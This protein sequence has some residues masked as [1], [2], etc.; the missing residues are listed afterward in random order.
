MNRFFQTIGSLE[1]ITTVFYATINIFQQKNVYILVITCLI[2]Q[3]FANVSFRKG[4]DFALFIA[5]KEYEEWADLRNPISDAEIIAGELA[6]EYDFDT[7]II[8]NPNR[9]TIYDVLDNYQKKSFP[10][11]SQLLVFFTG[12]GEFIEAN[13]EGYFIPND[14]KLND[15]Y[16]DSYIT[17]S[18]IRKRVNNINC[19]HVLL[20]IDACY[21]G[22]IDER[23]AS[24]ELSFDKGKPGTRPGESSQTTKQ[25]F[26]RRTL[27]HKTR[28]F[29]TSGG[30]ERTPD[31]IRYSP[32]TEHF[33]RGLRDYK[34]G[35]VTFWDLLAHLKRAH[36]VPHFGEFGHHVP[37]GDFI[38]VSNTNKETVLLNSPKLDAMPKDPSG[39]AYNTIE[40]NGKTWLKEN[41]AYDLEQ[42]SWCYDNKQ[43]NCLKYGCLYT[44]E[45][46]KK[47][48]ELLGEG[49]RLPTDEELK[50]L[51]K[52]AGGYYYWKTGKVGNNE[53]GYLELTKKGANGFSVLLSGAGAVF[54][55]LED[56]GDNYD[57]M[58]SEL[59]RFGYLWSSI[60]REPD[61]A[62]H[63]S[64]N[65]DSKRLYLDF[66][67][68]EH[69]FSCRC[70]KD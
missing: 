27:Q 1:M 56:E 60:E 6:R 37:G 13:S 59:D 45:A 22:T 47:S 15:R 2:L 21:S 40:L 12:H 5:V 58:F 38:F 53:K 69:A 65:G 68:V 57:M 32:F 64:F 63:L 66:E 55:S 52:F 29:L 62:W 48:C 28:L 3:A 19:N 31:G 8:R 26:I 51:A 46:A 42:G 33:L 25:A 18:E 54:P 36:P 17:L 7:M 43:D 34:N 50:D 44:W 24:E 49:W 11:D 23:L 14:G 39:R 35:L 61:F 41:L 4:K 10:E 9:N 20:A 30:K 70:I 16:Q 67:S